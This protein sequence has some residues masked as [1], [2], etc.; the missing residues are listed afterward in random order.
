MP[1]PTQKDTINLGKNAAFLRGKND[2]GGEEE[3]MLEGEGLILKA[4]VTSWPMGSRAGGIQSEGCSLPG[5]GDV[6]VLL[7]FS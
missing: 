5:N 6:V 3:L 1:Y 7:F 4:L 2:W